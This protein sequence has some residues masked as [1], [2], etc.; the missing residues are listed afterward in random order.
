[1]NFPP[2]RHHHGPA[3][4]SHC[5]MLSHWTTTF[6]ICSAWPTL[7]IDASRPAMRQR[8]S[9]EP[10]LLRNSGL[11]EPSRRDRHRRST[12][13][14]YGEEGLRWRS[15]ARFQAVEPGRYRK[16]LQ[17]VP[18]RRVRLWVKR[19]SSSPQARVKAATPIPCATN[20]SGALGN[21]VT[22]RRS[23][24]QTRGSVT[25]QVGLLQETSMRSGRR[26]G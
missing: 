14:P 2:L 21:P 18:I 23:F 24:L 15:S 9:F 17:N 12:L 7:G 26:H 13:R 6:E 11:E 4:H 3:G 20:S 1:M 10:L 19:F 5:W 25:A 16:D 8:G 22:R